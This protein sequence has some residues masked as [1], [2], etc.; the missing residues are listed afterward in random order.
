MVFLILLLF[1]LLIF[2]CTDYFLYISCTSCKSLYFIYADSHFCFIILSFFFLQFMHLVS[3]DNVVVVDNDD[4]LNLNWSSLSPC[5]RVQPISTKEN[6]CCSLIGCFPN[7]NYQ[8]VKY[9]YLF[10]G[11]ILKKS[12]NTQTFPIYSD[13]FMFCFCFHLINNESGNKFCLVHLKFNLS[14]I[15][16][17]KEK[18]SLCPNT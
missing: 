11:C 13:I 10:P 4:N 6:K 2:D 12:T 1:Y 17:Q 9:H 3:D 14:R 8:H 5:L 15:G 18:F 16:T 7:T